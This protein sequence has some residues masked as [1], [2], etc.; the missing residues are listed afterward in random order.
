MTG[1]NK[2]KLGQFFTNEQI[3]KFMCECI[4]SKHTKTL[5]DP[6]T[7]DGVFLKSALSLNNKL[8]CD[9]FELD[10]FFA[11]RLKSKNFSNTEILQQDYLISETDILY[12]AIIC[13]PPYNK[14]QEIKNRKTLQKNFKEKFNIEISGYSNLY[15]YFL[16]KSINELSENGKCC[17]IIPYEFLN[18]GY[19]EIV[20]KYLLES[21][22]LSTIIKFDN[23]IGLFDDAI[24]TSCIVILEKKQCNT[25]KFINI[26]DLKDFNINLIKTASNCHIYDNKDLNPKEKWLNLFELQNNIIN[27]ENLIPFIDYAQI[28]RGIATGN[29]KYFSLSNSKIKKLGLSKSACI[30]CITKSSDIKKYVLDE[31]EF[32]RLEISDK[33]VYIFDGTKAKIEDDFLYIKHGEKLGVNKTYLTSHRSPWF[34]IEQKEIAPILISVFNRDKIKFIRNKCN[35]K[36]LTTFHNLFFKQKSITEDEINIFFSYLLTPIAQEILYLNKR[37]YGNG[38]NKFEPNDLNNALVINIDKIE[39]NDKNKIIK[40]FN[41]LKNEENAIY[42]EGLNSIFLKYCCINI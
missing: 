22:M 11:Q 21:G 18:A 23:N 4:I 10:N 17:Y 38:L 27:Y 12:D 33:N 7:G 2:K 9:A 19:G 8:K 30:P 6:A 5:L 29:N 3:A 40:L 36:T 26:K 25:V 35:V 32:A 15:I 24:T 28:K 34:S 14:F 20:K 42:I 37:E 31:K 39:N 16:I 41:K 13:N 1:K